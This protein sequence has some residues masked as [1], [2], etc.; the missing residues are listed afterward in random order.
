MNPSVRRHVWPMVVA[1]LAGLWPTSAFCQEP[2][3][4][5]GH[6]GA[7]FCVA[8][9]P[10]G[11]RIVSGGTDETVKVWDARSGQK[12]LTLKG[13]T[14]IVF[15]VA[16]LTGSTFQNDAI[17]WFPSQVCDASRT[18]SHVTERE[19]EKPLHFEERGAFPTGVVPVRPCNRCVGH[20]SHLDV[21]VPIRAGKN[22][23]Y[24]GGAATWAAHWRKCWTTALAPMAQSLQILSAESR[25]SSVLI[26]RAQWP[27]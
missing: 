19:G 16:F 2:T 4:L 25:M 1:L 5:E 21:T 8:F 6:A 3:T 7:V 26:E 10:D 24:S 17:I 27:M 13:H 23:A 20:A 11:R 15:S 18:T 9:S 22:A 14:G 12:I